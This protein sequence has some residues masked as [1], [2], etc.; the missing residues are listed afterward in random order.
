MLM[1][2]ATPARQPGTAQITLGRYTHAL[3]EDVE[4]SRE[5]LADYLAEQQDAKAG[6]G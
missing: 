1:G 2:H 5:S 4:A 6:E 3:P